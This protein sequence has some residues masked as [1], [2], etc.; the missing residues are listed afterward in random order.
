MGTLHTTLHYTH[1]A[2]LGDPQILTDTRLENKGDSSEDE[3]DDIIDD[4]DDSECKRF[5]LEGL[6]AWC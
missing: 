4:V 5:K 1:I 3:E 6:R 2:N